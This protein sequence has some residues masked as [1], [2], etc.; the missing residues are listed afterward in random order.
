MVEED[1]GL[2]RRGSLAASHDSRQN[3]VCTLAPPGISL[4]PSDFVES[5]RLPTT[6]IEEHQARS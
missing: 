3:S 2:Q 1:G 4:I 6:P 5:H